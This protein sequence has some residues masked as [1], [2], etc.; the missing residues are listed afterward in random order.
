M[1]G[2]LRNLALVT[3]GHG[4]RPE[5]DALFAR[6]LAA[7]GLTPVIRSYHILDGLTPEAIGGLAAANDEPAILSRVRDDQGEVANRALARDKL[8]P[9]IEAALDWAEADGADAS[10]I[11]VAEHLR[12]RPRPRPALLPFALLA[13]RLHE[14][15]SGD[16]PVA[17]VAYGERQRVQQA[18]TWETFGRIVRERQRFL[19]AQADAGRL[20]REI[21]DA[22][23]R[24][25]AVLAF[26]YA[27][28]DD[29]SAEAFD[30]AQDDTGC[31]ILLPIRVTTEALVRMSGGTA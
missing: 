21:R 30:R 2:S 1:T 25:G 6:R 27:V 10:A 4:P 23:V 13:A 12:L 15:A 17:L 24:L 26:A 29:A 3:L 5:Y 14:L 19:T 22:G 8:L 31:T 18:E 11:C 16:E 7:A 20:L 28:S 9:L